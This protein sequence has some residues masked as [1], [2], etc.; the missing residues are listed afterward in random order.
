MSSM[1]Q[2]FLPQLVL[3]D[4]IQACFDNQKV[5]PDFLFQVLESPVII[6]FPPFPNLSY[7]E[8]PFVH[9]LEATG[10][11]SAFIA[12]G[13]PPGLVLDPDPIDGNLS[14]TPSTA[15][16]Y[17]T[18]LRAVYPDGSQAYQDYKFT[19]LAGAPQIS[20][21]SPQ[22]VTTNSL[23]VDYE[24]T[25]TGG[26]DPEVYLVADTVD[27]G[28][29]LYKW[30]FRL[31]L[32]KIGLGTGVAIL[33]GLNADAVYFVRMYAVNSA[34]EDWTGKESE[35]RYQP[36]K[37]HLPMALSVWFDATDPLADEKTKAIEGAFLS[38]WR[39]KSGFE[40]DMDNVEV[41]QPSKMDGYRESS[42]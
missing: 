32:G 14:G 2:G 20:M 3:A 23:S 40:R 4:W 35:I 28:K 6:A 36:L 24:V 7:A 8:Q 13:L 16:L 21:S 22:T 39:D 42:S 31:A 12:S 18:Q 11:P 37:N 17:Q 9:N 27:H 29:D 25:A 38:T 10:S 19:V 5:N 33:D 34:G 30:K 1:K 41:I 26:D 15:G